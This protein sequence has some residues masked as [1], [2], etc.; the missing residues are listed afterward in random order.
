M[1]DKPR[2]AVLKLIR[3]TQDGKVEWQVERKFH[4]TTKDQQDDRIATAFTTSYMGKNLILY[5]RIYKA[6]RLRTGA[7][8]DL[9]HTSKY[10]EYWDSEVVLEIV[11]KGTALWAFPKGSSQRE[12]LSSVQYQVA[13]VKDCLDEILSEDDSE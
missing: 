13:G 3:L 1:P 11:D 8:R 10:E 6:Y 9:L 2:D 4:Y 7:F 5:E 12:L